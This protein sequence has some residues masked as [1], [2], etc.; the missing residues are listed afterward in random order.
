[1]VSHTDI[2]INN[3]HEKLEFTDTGETPTGLLCVCLFVH[4]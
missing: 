2:I 4:F 1:M 3:R